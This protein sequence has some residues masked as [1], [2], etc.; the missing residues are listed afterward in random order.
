MKNNNQV[1][2]KLPG[3]PIANGSQHLSAA[4]QTK[5]FY[6]HLARVIGLHNHLAALTYA[7]SDSDRILGSL[8]A[9]YIGA[10]H[11]DMGIAGSSNLHTWF[12]QLVGAYAHTYRIYYEQYSTAAHAAPFLTVV[13]YPHSSA[14]G[15]IAMDMMGMKTSIDAKIRRQ[16][17][18][19]YTSR[20]MEY[21]AKN[22]LP[23][24]SFVF[25]DN[26]YQGALIQWTATV[27][28]GGKDVAT[29]IASTK[30]EAKHLAS[31]D[32]LLSLRAPTA[33]IP[34]LRRS[35]KLQTRRMVIG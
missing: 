8:F 27:G 3:E 13:Q 22:H 17:A 6:A 1:A 18:S 26:G 10:I 15:T 30:L 12:A 21:A 33:Q 2:S 35:K 28:V 4:L 7:A 29:A 9:S 19:V 16:N 20:L 34:S 25:Q 23:Q 14:P 5:T 31:R 11:R 24:P 32:A